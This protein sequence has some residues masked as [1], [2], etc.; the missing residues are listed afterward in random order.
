MI[1]RLSGARH[2]KAL[3]GLF[4]VDGYE[5]PCCGDGLRRARFDGLLMN[6]SLHSA[7]KAT[8][9]KTMLVSVVCCVVIVGFALLAKTQPENRFVLLKAN[10]LIRAA[11]QAMPAN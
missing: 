5:R 7:D 4:A 10:K 3:S 8:Y 2:V 9:R 11:G 1:Y 6:H